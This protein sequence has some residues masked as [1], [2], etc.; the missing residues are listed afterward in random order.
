MYRVG[1]TGKFKFLKSLSPSLL[2]FLSR[3][4]LTISPLFSFVYL[5][6]P[7]PQVVMPRSPIQ[8]KGLLLACVR[9]PN[10]CVFFEPKILYRSAV[11]EVPE[12]E[13]TLP[14]GTA[15]IVRSGEWSGVIPKLRR[16]ASNKPAISQQ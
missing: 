14:L 5:I 7:L 10:P 1:K 9:D 4:I 3:S 15:E 13:Y 16:S 11:E 8:A 12:V 2:F 6:L